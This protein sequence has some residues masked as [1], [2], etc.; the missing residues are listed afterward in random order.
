MIHVDTSF[1]IHALVAG[2]PEDRQLRHW[3]DG[4][5]PLGMSAIAW[6]EFLCGPAAGPPPEPPAGIL[7]EIVPYTEQDAALAASLFNRSGR[8]RGS[9]GDCMVAA[10]AL[11]REAS[12][13]TSNPEDFRRFHFSDLEVIRLET[14]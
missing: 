3:I 6:T 12:L 2:S 9:M 4:N 7:S 13:A 5:E 14:L 1:L 11:R 10:C 8:R